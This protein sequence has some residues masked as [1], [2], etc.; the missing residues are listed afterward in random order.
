[1]GCSK[2]GD[3]LDV[4]FVA[5]GNTETVLRNTEVRNVLKKLRDGVTIVTDGVT[6][7]TNGVT[8]VTIAPLEAGSCEEKA[9]SREK[10]GVNTEVSKEGRGES[11]QEHT[12]SEERRQEQTGADKTR[13]EKTKADKTAVTPPDTC[14]STGDGIGITL[15]SGGGGESEVKGEGNGGGSDDG[16]GDG[17][18]EGD[19]DEE[20]YDEDDDEVVTRLNLDNSDWQAELN[21]RQPQVTLLLHYCYT[22][23]A[24]WLRCSYTIVT[25]VIGRL[26]CTPDSLRHHPFSST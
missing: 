2:I 14:E 11:R 6:G 3:T 21:T 23:G 1:V 7:V 18:E 15:S 8:V 19:E 24:L 10:T 17:G 22:I 16:D 26:S 13:P 25:M 4:L 12:R 20:D 5:Y 9:E